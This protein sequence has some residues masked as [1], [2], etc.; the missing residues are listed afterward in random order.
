LNE[1]LSE[2]SHLQQA[3]VRIVT[4]IPL[5]L[6]SEAH[7]ARLDCHQNF[8]FADVVNCPSEMRPLQV[9]TNGNPSRR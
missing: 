4:K 7:Q 1:G 2:L 9:E 5:D 8:V 3:G 6:A